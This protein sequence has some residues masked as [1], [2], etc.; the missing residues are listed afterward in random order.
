MDCS[1]ESEL[2]Y[3]ALAEWRMRWML[4]TKMIMYK[5]LS[6]VV[7]RCAAAPSQLRP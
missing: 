6:C 7:L 5:M 3:A 2:D 4:I 1:N